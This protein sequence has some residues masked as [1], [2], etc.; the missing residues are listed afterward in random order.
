MKRIAL[1]AVLLVSLV[2]LARAGFDEGFAAYER[3]DYETALKKWH[4]LAEQGHAEAQNSLGLMYSKGEGVPHDYVEAMRWYRLAA[5]QGHATAQFNLADMYKYGKGVTQG[6]VQAYMWWSVA[7]ANGFEEANIHRD[8]VAE[9][10]T[11]ADISKAQ[12][13]AREWMEKHQE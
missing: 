6:Y 11:P 1:A 8:I 9:W 4:P 5:E 3:G 2:G 13:M 7:G 12:A 10:M